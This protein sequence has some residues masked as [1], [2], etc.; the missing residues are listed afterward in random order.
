[1]KADSS[2]S[3]HPLICPEIGNLARIHRRNRLLAEFSQVPIARFFGHHTLFD[4][5]YLPVM[6]WAA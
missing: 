5:C 6:E 2:S 4:A 1:M 3:I